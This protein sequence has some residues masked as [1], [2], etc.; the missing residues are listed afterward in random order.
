MGAGLKTS[1]PQCAGAR[2]GRHTEVGSFPFV[3]GGGHVL[4]SR[5]ASASVPLAQSHSQV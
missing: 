2:S 1:F 4:R 3:A 5:R